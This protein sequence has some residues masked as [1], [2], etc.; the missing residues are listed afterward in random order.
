M[1]KP[2]NTLGGLRKKLSK[3]NN[4]SNGTDEDTKKLNKSMADLFGIIPLWNY[5]E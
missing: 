2:I 4:I 5:S 3:L 1:K